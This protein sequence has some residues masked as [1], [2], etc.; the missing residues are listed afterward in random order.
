MEADNA[1]K[2]AYYF[3]YSQNRWG[4]EPWRKVTGDKTQEQAGSAYKGL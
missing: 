2:N 4:I 3:H 1:G